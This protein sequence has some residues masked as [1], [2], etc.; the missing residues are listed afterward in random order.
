MGDGIVWVT[1]TEVWI[2]A[3]TADQSSSLNTL[4]KL[5]RA[6]DGSGL[7]IAVYVVDANGNVVMKKSGR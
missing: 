3:S 2:S 7:P 1:A 5:W 4:Y 6:A